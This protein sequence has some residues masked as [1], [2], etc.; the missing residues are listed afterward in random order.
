MVIYG[1]KTMI[2]LYIWKIHEV[3]KL[4]EICM[5][6]ILGRYPEGMTRLHGL[7]FSETNIIKLEQNRRVST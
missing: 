1:D 6:I 5:D 7:D 4:D 2:K 3:K